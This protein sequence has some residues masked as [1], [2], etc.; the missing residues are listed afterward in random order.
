MWQILF[1]FI[2]LNTYVPLIFH[3]KIQPKVSSGSGEKVDFV[4]FAIFSNFFWC[5]ARGGARI[6]EFF[7]K[8]QNL[9]EKFGGG[10]FR[11]GGGEGRG[12]GV[13]ELFLLWIQI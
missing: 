9:K 13:S 4:I 5:G 1:I 10:G 2:I 11:E 6:S 12:A 7:T 3:A 8:N